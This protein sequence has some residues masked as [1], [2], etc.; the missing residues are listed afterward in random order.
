MAAMPVE[1]QHLAPVIMTAS[2][3]REIIRHANLKEQL[4]RLRK[5]KTFWTHESDRAQSRLQATMDTLE[6]V[7]E[8]FLASCSARKRVYA[9]VDY[10]L[11]ADREDAEHLKD[12]EDAELALHIK[13]RNIG[14]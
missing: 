6:A 5:D 8:K 2:E 3:R 11:K 13:R 14:K 7:D 1:Q 10:H 4:A 12:I 9:R